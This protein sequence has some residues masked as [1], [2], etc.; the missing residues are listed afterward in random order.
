MMRTRPSVA[1]VV[2]CYNTSGACED[3]LVR[4]QQS[5]DAVLAIDDGST[6]DTLAHIKASGC[7]YLHFDT[8]AGKGVALRAGIAEVLKGSDGVLG[9]TFDYILTVDGDGQ[10]DPGEIPRFIERTAM[11]DADLV[12]GV[13][14]VRLMPPKSKIGNY[15]SRVLFFLG[16]GAYVA[17]TQSGFRL[18]STTLAQSLLPAVAWRR[19]ETEADILAK[20]VALGYRV[21]TMEIPTIYFDRNKRTHFDPLWDS[22]R[23]VAVLSRYALSSL[24]VTAVDVGAFVLL[25]PVLNG[26]LVATNAG[27]RACAVLVHFLLSRAYAFRVRGTVH[28]AEIVKYGLTVLLNLWFTTWLLIRLRNASLDTVSAKIV[29]QTIGFIITFIVLER[30]VFRPSA[31]GRTNWDEYY[32]NPVATAGWSRGIMARQLVAAIRQ[33]A[34]NRTDL[35]VLELGG[36]NSCFLERLMADGHIGSYTI[37]DSSPEGMRLARERFAPSYGARVRYIEADAFSVRADR[38]FDVVYSVGLIEHFGEKELQ[39]LVALHREWATPGGLVIIVVPTPTIF[40]RIIRGAAELL[41]IWRFPDEVPIPRRR[42]VALADNAGLRVIFQK[43]LWSQL[44]TQAI[45]AAHPATAD[46]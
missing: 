15:F 9:R 19:Y 27:S 44:V 13:R 18:I 45:I 42:L 11:A 14:N 32:R 43:T 36:G 21:D 34:G 30:F 3:V 12:I 31:G 39:R 20:T 22:M 35:T 28:L 1:V 2:P 7:S 8:N 46:R 10:H 4:A 24:A 26:N 40:Y 29:A 25:L 41:G 17:D 6:D 38:R 16:T 37:L 23:V 5:A 33:F